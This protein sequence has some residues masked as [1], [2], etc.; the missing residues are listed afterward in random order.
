MIRIDK[1]RFDDTRYAVTLVDGG[2]IAS[3][4]FSSN[5]DA[6]DAIYLLETAFKLGKVQYT[7]K[8][9]E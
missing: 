1:E 3:G 7:T 5:E 8:E 6:D 2:I 9:A 4:F